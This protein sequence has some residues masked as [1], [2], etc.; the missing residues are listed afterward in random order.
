MNITD[1]FDEK[2]WEELRA[3]LESF[4]RWKLWGLRRSDRSSDDAI[5]STFRTFLDRLHNGEARDESRRDPLPETEE[6]VLQLLFKHLR[7]KIRDSRRQ[8]NTKKRSA[9]RSSDVSAEAARLFFDQFSTERKISDADLDLFFEAALQPLAEFSEESQR[10]AFMLLQGYTIK[11]ISELTD[12]PLHTVYA[13]RARLRE[14]ADNF[15]RELE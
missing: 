13:E 8:E 12:R 5:N 6:E 1:S 14:W 10:F 7:R 11:E 9:L 2:K 4:S 3:K 15:E